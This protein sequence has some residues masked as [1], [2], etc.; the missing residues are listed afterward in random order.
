[1][2]ICVTSTPC[3]TRA[4]QKYGG[5]T[6]SDSVHSRVER[7]RTAVKLTRLMA[8]YVYARCLPYI[9]GALG[10][11]AIYVWL[12]QNWTE[13]NVAWSPQGS[14]FATFHQPGTCYLYVAWIEREFLCL[15][16]FV[17]LCR[18]YSVGRRILRKDR[19]FRPPGCQTHRFL[20]QREL[21][22]YMQQEGQGSRG[23][24]IC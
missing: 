17:R 5:T 13:L 15:V 4:K 22:G 11:T 7:L 3:V 23:I 24:R 20:A 18:Y 16:F 1:M 6:H 14:Y 2:S 12:L 8:R 9:Y 10:V 19:T 21:Y